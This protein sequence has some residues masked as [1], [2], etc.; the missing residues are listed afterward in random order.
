MVLTQVLLPYLNMFFPALC[1]CCGKFPAGYPSPVCGRC[2][3]SILRE[4]PPSPRVTRHLKVWSCRNY[5]G[6]IRECI[7]EFKYGKNLGVLPLFRALA[8]EYVLLNRSRIEDIDLVIPIP[9]HPARTRARGFNQAETISNLLSPDLS[10]A[11]PC[12]GL[13]KTKMTRPQTGLSRKE[14]LKNLKGSFIV[15]DRLRI[16]GRSVLLVDD[17]VTTGATLD[18]CA[19]L[20][21]K[22]GARKVIGFTIASARG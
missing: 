16:A 12:R 5:E 18:T 13:V 11:T 3:E 10:Q 4:L 9:A 1:P 21:L 8:R 6:A 7:K 20:L 15:T 14:R 2:N 22:A 19:A 17:I